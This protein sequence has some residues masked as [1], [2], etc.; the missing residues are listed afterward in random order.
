M[1]LRALFK[2][3]TSTISSR[4]WG[5][6]VAVSAIK[7]ESGKCSRNSPSAAYS[8][9]KSWPHWET[10]C[11]SSTAISPMRIDSRLWMKPGRIIRSGATYSRS[12]SP[13]CR[14]SST[15]LASPA[16]RLELYIAAFTPLACSASTWS[17]ISEISGEITMANPSVCKAGNW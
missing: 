15:H 8:G 2:P 14:R 17:F 9:R 16:S 5:S 3:S 10:Q 7:G 12:S 6:A 4:V 11:A 13:P 1:N